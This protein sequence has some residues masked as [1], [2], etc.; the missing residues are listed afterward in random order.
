[1]F[2]WRVRTLLELF[3]RH[4]P[5]TCARLNQLR[6]FV[7][8][9]DR[10]D[11]IREVFSS[12][13]RVSIDYG[14]L[15]KASGLRLIPARFG[16]DDIGGWGALERT[17][18][19]DAAG[20]VTRGSSVA[21]ESGDCVLFSD[22][23]TVAAFGVRGLVVVQARGRVLVCPRERTADLKRLVSALPQEMK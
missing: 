2:L 22:A 3:E 10:P 16:W 1:M 4:M 20:N 5:D 7:G 6:P 17:M 23:G 14:I 18:E 8:R 15:E 13:E 19:A 21:V 12:I 11:K 9:S